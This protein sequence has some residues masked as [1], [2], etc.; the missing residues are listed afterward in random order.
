MLEHDKKADIFLASMGVC[1][2]TEDTM[3]HEEKH[4]YIAK[5]GEGVKARYFYTQEALDAYKKAL[6]SKDEKAALEKGTADTQKMRDSMYTKSY[7]SKEEEAKDVEKYNKMMDKN[8]AN[9]DA[10]I[11]A[12]TMKGKLEAVKETRAELAKAKQER[13]RTET[14][15]K[16]AD[17]VKQTTE[18]PKTKTKKELGSGVKEY[19]KALTS[20]DEKRKSDAAYAKSEKAKA[21]FEKKE[22]AYNELEGTLKFKKKKEARAEM[23]KAAAAANKAN[24]ENTKALNEY[25][26]SKNTSKA[27]AVA[28]VFDKRNPEV[29]KRIKKGRDWAKSRLK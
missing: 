26:D 20:E 5:I 13:A 16:E 8:D 19:A 23:E 28:E 10:Y 1:M 11:K 29:S 15:K 25:L 2:H 18:A 12:K 27:K 24:A 17:P 6:S 14:V 22:A 21:D 3:A 4:K 7:A 9:A